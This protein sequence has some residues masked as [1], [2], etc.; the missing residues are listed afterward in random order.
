MDSANN[1]NQIKASVEDLGNGRY[2][3]KAW[4]GSG[5]YENSKHKSIRTTPEGGKFFNSG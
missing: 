4:Y 2:E 3:V 1:D 5:N